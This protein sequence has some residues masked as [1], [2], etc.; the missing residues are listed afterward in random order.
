[1]VESSQNGARSGDYYGCCGR[2]VICCFNKENVGSMK[3]LLRNGF[4]IYDEVQAEGD[5]VALF[6]LDMPR[7]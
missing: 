3:V 2:E 4:R 7:N 5:T 1:M 6:D